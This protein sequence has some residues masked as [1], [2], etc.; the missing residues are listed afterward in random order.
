MIKYLLKIK[1]KITKLDKIAQN[2]FIQ[3]SHTY[4]PCQNCMNQTYIWIEEDSQNKFFGS[5]T[6]T[7]PFKKK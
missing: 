1:N 3:E 6:T 2:P 7:N 4:N 5:N